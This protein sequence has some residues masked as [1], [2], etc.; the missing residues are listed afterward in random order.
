M[1]SNKP[2]FVEVEEA[3]VGRFECTVTKE[4][5]GIREKEVEALRIVKALPTRKQKEILEHVK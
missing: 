1:Q 2:Q 4:Y 5:Y 3:K